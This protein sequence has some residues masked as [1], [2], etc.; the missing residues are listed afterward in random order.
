MISETP[1][2][3]DQQWQP[4]PAGEVAGLVKNL[5]QRRRS[6]RL[7]TMSVAVCGLAVAGLIGLYAVPHPL[8]VEPSFGGVSCSEVKELAD[9]Y[10][11]GRLDSE[12]R[13]HIDEHLRACDRCQ[14]LVTELRS[15]QVARVQPDSVTQPADFSSDATLAVNA[16]SAW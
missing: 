13:A 15:R 5:R 2:Q 9:E 11:A 4:C 14:Q 7:Q 12:T 3:N 1:E 6:R 8:L 10:I 16:R